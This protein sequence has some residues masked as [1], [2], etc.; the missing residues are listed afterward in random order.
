M[1]RLLIGFALLLL[2][3]PDDGA[4]QGRR[5]N[6]A[7]QARRYAEA[8]EH[9]R[10]G[11]LLTQDPILRFGLQYNLGAA[12]LRLG[13]TGAA[14]AAFDA[15]FRLA[16]DADRQARAAY[17][18][19]N[20]AFAA[21]NL[22]A[23]L[24]YYRTALLA[25]PDLEDARFNYEYVLRHLASSNPPPPSAGG[26]EQNNPNGSEPP[27]ALT[28][29]LAGSDLQQNADVS[30]AANDTGSQTPLASERLK[31]PAQSTQLLPEAAA[32]LLEALKRQEREALQR[33]FRLP[34]P[35]R[36]VEKDW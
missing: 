13:E 23:A 24:Q 31:T 15:A 12:L 36:K 27:N 14:R 34:T 7:Y 29:G 20:A 11:L 16:S 1:M 26:T 2:L 8:A 4:R 9:Y 3:L 10:Q 18:A 6:A 33:A 19:G 21:G 17:N 28:Q 22:Q 32:Q 25:A 5:G 35:P 30:P